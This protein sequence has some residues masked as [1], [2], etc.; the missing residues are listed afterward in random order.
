MQLIDS[1]GGLLSQPPQFPQA[2]DLIQSELWHSCCFC[3]GSIMLR[4]ACL[5]SASPYDE[6]LKPAEDYDLWLRLAEVTQLANLAAP[7]YQFRL[8]AGSQSSQ[9]RPV[10]LYHAAMALEHA[11]RR[12]WREA[13]PAQPVTLTAGHY[14]EAAVLAFGAGDQALAA[15]SLASGLAVAPDL[16]KA[17]EPLL[18]ILS[19]ATYAASAEAAV[20]FCQSLFADLLPQTRRLSQLKARFIS[21]LHMK[22]VYRQ[23]RSG[24]VARPKEHLLPSIRHDPSWLLNRGVLAILIRSSLTRPGR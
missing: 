22:V 21:R 19:N 5:P 8:H 15:A 7:L 16:L 24:R 4:R 17:D 23:L 6:S 14:L 10:Q 2:N 1:D 13:F 20:A 3:H 18:T 9:K 12:R 11:L